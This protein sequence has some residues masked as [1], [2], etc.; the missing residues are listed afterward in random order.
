MVGGRQH[1]ELNRIF[2]HAFFIFMNVAFGKAVH[3]LAKIGEDLYLETSID[4]V[5][6]DYVL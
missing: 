3:C 4:K 2:T 5:C 6:T 1:V